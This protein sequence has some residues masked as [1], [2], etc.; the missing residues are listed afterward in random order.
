M[1]SSSRKTRLRNSSCGAR[2][3]VLVG[4]LLL[5]LLLPCSLR[6]GSLPDPAAMT[7]QE[8][9]AE[10]Q[11]ILERQESRSQL[12]RQVLPQVQRTLSI[13]PQEL[14]ILASSY[15]QWSLDLSR[16]S[17]IVTALSSSFSNFAEESDREMAALRR[18]NT[19]LKLGI[20][21]TAAAALTALILALV[22]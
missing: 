7:D 12:Q 16:T 15:N 10:M 21:A 5:F 18:E 17:G 4:L 6:A 9:V 11:Q 13:S 20:G 22:N 19:W 1:W 14:R 2:S 3:I 8:I